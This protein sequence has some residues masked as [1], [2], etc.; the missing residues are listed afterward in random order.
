MELCVEQKFTITDEIAER[1]TAPKG[2]GLDEQTRVRL[3]EKMG[4]CCT[5][6]GSYHLAAKKYTQAGNKVSNNKFMYGN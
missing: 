4:E 6:Q 1:L 5:L 2:I 3:L